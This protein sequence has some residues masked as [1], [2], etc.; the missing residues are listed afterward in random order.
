MKTISY[1]PHEAQQHVNRAKASE[2]KDSS[3]YIT[4][5]SYH[6]TKSDDLIPHAPGHNHSPEHG[7]DKPLP[8]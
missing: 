4:A 2:E 6:Q 3:G 1:P 5:D 8:G 7:L